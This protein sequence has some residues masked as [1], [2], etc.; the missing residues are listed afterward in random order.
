MNKE[1]RTELVALL[2]DGQ[3]VAVDGLVIKAIRLP[4]W[5][6]GI[7]CDHCDMDCLCKG[8]IADICNEINSIG[9]KPYILRLC[10]SKNG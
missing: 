4:E 2:R 6:M 9:V 1:K 5:A 3:R 7:Y 10:H 8:N